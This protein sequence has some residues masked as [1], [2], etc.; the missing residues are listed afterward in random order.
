M[1]HRLLSPSLAAALV[2]AASLSS[3]QTSRN[4]SGHWEGSFTAGAGPVAVQLDLTV[5]S[6]GAVAGTIS[7][8][9][10]NA[11]PLMRVAMSGETLTFDVP[12]SDGARF[13]G[14]LSAD[15]KT[16]VGE[17]SNGAGA[18]PSTLTRTGDAQAHGAIRSAAVGKEMEGQWS[19]VLSVEG[20]QKRVTLKIA[21][22]ADNSAVASVVSVDDGGIELPVEVVQK[23]NR[24]EVSIRATGAGFAVMLDPSAGELSGTYIERQLAF[25]ISFRR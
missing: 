9:T 5:N 4:P 12:G 23:G 6:A 18:A 10:V 2:L 25:P 8:A 20:L 19:G 7:T 14:V 15:G 21:N 13:S 3:A 1:G 16:I 17:F 24:L 11:L 22:Q